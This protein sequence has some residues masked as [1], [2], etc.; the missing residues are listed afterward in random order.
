MKIRKFLKVPVILGITLFT[1][2]TA[3]AKSQRGTTSCTYGTNSATLEVK[4]GY[5]YVSGASNITS[6]AG[7]G[8]A[9][10]VVENTALIESLSKSTITGDLYSSSTNTLYGLPG[11]KGT[12]YYGICTNNATTITGST[13]ITLKASPIAGN[14]SGGFQEKNKTVTVKDG[15]NHPYGKLVV[16]Y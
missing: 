15:G 9:L 11:E 12:L 13:N 16:T 2:T 10:Q 1:V 3:F 8:F 5:G 7:V 6:G 4:N 14:K